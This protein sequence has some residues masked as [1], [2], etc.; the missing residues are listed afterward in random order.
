VILDS[1]FHVWDASQGGHDWLEGAPN[2]APCYTVAQYEA[3]ARAND[4]EGAVLVQVRNDAAET[5]E[6]LEL[7]S[8]STLVNGVVGW[9]NLEAPDVNDHL[10]ALQESPHGSLLV[11]VR[12]LVE[13]ESDPQYLERDSVQRGLSAVAA[14]GLVFDLLVRPRQLASALRAVRACEDLRVVLDHAGFPNVTDL[15]QDAWATN[16]GELAQTGRV[17]CKLSGFVTE[18]GSRGSDVHVRATVSFLVETFTT[19]SLLFGSDWPVCL[20]VAPFEEVLTLA[21]VSVAD[22][23]TSEREDVFGENARRWYQVDRYD[24]RAR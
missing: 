18:L 9:I 19:R 4:V 15:D 16:V 6:F 10:T 20:Q 3:T 14:S 7:A 24:Q 21:R 2:L 11:G 12:H 5:L 1:H 23:S 8:Q 17:A 22:L 13:G